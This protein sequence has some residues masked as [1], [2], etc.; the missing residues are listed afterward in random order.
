ML[1]PAQ[2]H[3]QR[4]M[5]ERRGQADEESD[6]QRTAHEQILH[7]LRMD[8]SRLSGVQSEETK[9]EMKKSMLPEY[10]G[11]IE[12]TLDG[13]SGRQDEVITR[14]MV[15]AIDCRDYAL[16]LRL[17][18]YVV[19]HGLTLPDNFNRTAATFLTEE[20]SK[21]VLTLAA[22]DADADLSAS[23]AVLDEVAD[24]VADS[25]MPDVVRAKLCKARA[26]ARRGATDITTKAEALALFREALTRNTNAG[27]K[28]EI[29][30]LAREVKK[31][32]ADSGT[33][34]GDSASTDKTDG[35]ADPVPEKSATASAAGKATTRKT[36][37]RAATGKTTKRKPASQK[38]N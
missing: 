36:T 16:A 37:T 24:I 11:W 8:L 26:L 13:D 17:G 27:V 29:A 20:M 21:P 15:W 31:L 4:V 18:R 35:T 2:R 5:A 14:L 9:A 6:I 1:T 33:G 22:A 38:K 28:K 34:E 3:F 7:R 19:R 32:S 25:D 30:T 12:G 10:D 23:T